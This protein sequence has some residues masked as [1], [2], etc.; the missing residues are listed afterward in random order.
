MAQV[1]NAVFTPIRIGSGEK[2]RELDLQ[3]LPPITMGD[4]KKL[5]VELKLDMRKALD[6][7]PEEDIAL[8]C[9]LLRK[10]DPTVTSEEVEA[11]P[12]V[13]GQSITTYA[14][15]VTQVVDR[16]FSLQSTASPPRTD[17]D[18]PKLSVLPVPS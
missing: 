14:G 3:K 5:L 18:F 10:L 2:T 17:G 12:T 8:V 15:M 1:E 4:R 11:L 16:P 7:T 9:Y 6:F 13:V